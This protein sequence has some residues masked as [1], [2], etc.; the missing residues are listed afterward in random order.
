MQLARSFDQGL[1]A[2]M[3]VILEKNQLMKN[4]KPT[5]YPTYRLSCIL[6]KYAV[7][8][9]YYTILLDPTHAQCNM[10]CIQL[11]KHK[12]G[13]KTFALLVLMFE[14]CVKD[15]LHGIEEMC[16]VTCTPAVQN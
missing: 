16:T 10:H 4:F 8:Y 5:I 6:F 3:K 1:E 14:L 15:R 13:T 12:P 2:L 9:H 7:Q 11:G